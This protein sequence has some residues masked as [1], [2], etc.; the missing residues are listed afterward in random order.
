MATYKAANMAGGRIVHREDAKSAM[1]DDE[2]DHNIFMI[3]FVSS[4]MPALTNHHRSWRWPNVALRSAKER[5]CF[6]WRT[7]VP[8]RS[9]GPW[10]GLEY[11]RPALVVM[12]ENRLFHPGPFPLRSLHLRGEKK[13]QPTIARESSR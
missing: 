11:L 8:S 5:A 9:D 4:P 6:A 2:P 12:S 10:L 3:C 1:E 13:T 7:E